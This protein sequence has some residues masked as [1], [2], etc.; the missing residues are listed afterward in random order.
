MVLLLV[1]ALLAACVRGASRSNFSSQDFPLVAR[2][3]AGF[4][5]RAVWGGGLG[6][7]GG[8]AWA[9]SGDSASA[10]VVGATHGLG[11]GLLV[12]GL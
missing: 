1:A 8:L 10:S 4:C 5:A 2:C 12:G 7:H 11:L 9:W 3:V 6:S